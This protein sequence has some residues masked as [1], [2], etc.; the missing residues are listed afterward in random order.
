MTRTALAV[1]LAISL[2]GCAAAPNQTGKTVCAPWSGDACESKAKHSRWSIALFRADE[3]EPSVWGHDEG[4]RARPIAE[5]YCRTVTAPWQAP[6][7]RVEVTRVKTG[8]TTVLNCQ[9]TD[10]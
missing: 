9:S 5:M 1:L 7:V 8:E 4:F 3:T 2:S 6:I 10:S